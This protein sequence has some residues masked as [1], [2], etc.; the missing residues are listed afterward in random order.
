MFT[1]TG[2]MRRRIVTRWLAIGNTGFE[3]FSGVESLLP[4]P[5]LYSRKY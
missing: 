1:F 5:V 4:N 2:R 3:A